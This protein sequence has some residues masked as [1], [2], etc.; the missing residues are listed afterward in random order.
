VRAV[1]G[2]SLSAASYPPVF[3]EADQPVR[4]ISEP[5]RVARTRRDRRVVVRRALVSAD[6]I[7]LV[8][9]FGAVEAI[10]GAPAVASR[11]F[12]VK[13]ALVALALPT[14]VIAAQ[15]LGLYDRDGARTFH[16]TIDDFNGVFQLVTLASWITFPVSWAIGLTPPNPLKMVLLWIFALSLVM[17]GRG[18]ARSASRRVPAYIQDAIIVGAG[19]VGQLVGRK[20]LQH[21]EYGLR[22]VGFVDARPRERRSELEG[23]GVLG[24]LDELPRLVANLGVERVIVAFSNES[25]QELLDVVRL[26][27]GTSAQVDIVPRLFE[28]VGLR[29]HLHDV[30]GLPL[31]GLAPT[32]LSRSGRLVKRAFDILGSALILLVTAPLFVYIALRIK[33]DSSGPVIFR[34][35]RLGMR[36]EPFTVL[37]F[38]TM[39]TGADT[40]EHREFIQQTMSAS[41]SVGSNGLYKLE[42]PHAVT[43]FGR[44]LRKTSLDELPQLVNV[45]RGSMSLVGPRPCIPYETEFFAPHHFE[46]FQVPAGITGLWQVTARALSTFGE[47][48]E[49]DVMYV[50]GW[51][52]G[53]DLRLLLLTPIQ[54]LRGRGTT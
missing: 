26:L 1:R 46:R 38:R 49:L 42:Q 43:N 15:A 41:A 18:I 22:L 19:D 9:A 20:L 47:A 48:L 7:A 52:L 45:L 23:V 40:N 5:A 11:E 37:K 3:V 25:H 14:W 31:L 36:M 44:W 32:R 8:A 4:W 27:R 10:V 54:L 13:A 17:V 51:S 34:Q 35:T 50:R 2:R 53:M 33:A 30:E 28:A 12:L 29:A 39:S 16:P 24:Q 6:C 21:P